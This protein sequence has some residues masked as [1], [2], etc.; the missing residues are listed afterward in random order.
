MDF[1][2]KQGSRFYKMTVEIIQKNESIELYKVYARG[3]TSNYIILQNNRPMIRERYKLKTKSL[4]WKVIEGEIKNRR[5]L[6]EVIKIL[7]FWIE[8]HHGF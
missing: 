7:E 5:A 3:N 6:N 4:T 1:S 8:P 2:L